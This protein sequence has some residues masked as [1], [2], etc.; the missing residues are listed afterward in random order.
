MV[1]AS[2][3]AHDLAPNNQSASSKHQSLAGIYPSPEPTNHSALDGTT[4]QSA[5]NMATD[6]VNQP[7]RKDSI[8]NNSDHLSN[9]DSGTTTQWNQKYDLHDFTPD[10]SISFAPTNPFYNSDSIFS[11]T[12]TTNQ[13]STSLPQPQ[14]WAIYEQT[15]QKTSPGQFDSTDNFDIAEYAPLAMKHSYS[16]FTPIQQKQTYIQPAHVQ[17]PISP[18][19]HTEWASPA[20]QGGQRHPL[21]KQMRPNTHVRSLSEC[22]RPDG[23]RKKNTRI[24][25]P[26]E[27]SLVAIERLLEDSKNDDERKEL[28]GQR[29]LLRNREA[30]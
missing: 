24:D 16:S 20:A 27:R 4:L 7:F 5:I 8:M 14:T 18:H 11:R 21:R 1:F 12:D 3:C 28:K 2:P 6:N 30:A 10:D 9:Y 25:I 15:N 13:A 17:T 19:S 29:R 22:A 23:I 26:P